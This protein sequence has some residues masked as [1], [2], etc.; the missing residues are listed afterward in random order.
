MVSA[1]PPV[2]LTISDTWYVPGAVKLWEG[3]GKVETLLLP[4]GGSP[5]F[6]DQ[7]AKPP[8]PACDKSLNTTGEPAHEVAYEK[9][10]KGFGNI[11][12]GITI[13]RLQLSLVVTVRET[14]KVA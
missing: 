14:L 13:V 7:P 10:A 6:H 2:L 3:D 1:H 5:K 8:D 9:F 11:V 12:I 4:E